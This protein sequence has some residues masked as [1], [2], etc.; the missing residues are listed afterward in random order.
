I[1]TARLRRACPINSRQRGFIAA[2]GCA[3]NLKLLQMLIRYVKKDH[4]LLGVVFVD[5]AKAFD[6]VQH[7][8]IFQVLRQKGV[9]SHIID[10]I[11]KMYNNSAT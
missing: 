10:I 6:S 11:A 9:D 7:H 5:L 1:L 4:K 8:L 2:P 3:E